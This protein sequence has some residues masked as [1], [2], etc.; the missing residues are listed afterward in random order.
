MKNP[1][2]KNFRGFKSRIRI[3]LYPNLSR[4]L[5]ICFFDIFSMNFHLIESLLRSKFEKYFQLIFNKIYKLPKEN[6][7]SV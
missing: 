2:Y 3:V 7:F 6:S 5:K 4:G 1:V